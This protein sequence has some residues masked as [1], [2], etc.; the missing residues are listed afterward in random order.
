MK[1]ILSLVFVIIV[2]VT[3]FASC[4]SDDHEHSYSNGKCSCG[5]VDPNYHKHSF[6]NGKCS[7]GAIDPNHR[8]SFVEG[9]CACGEEDPNYIPP[10]K[11]T[12]VDGKCKDCAITDPDVKPDYGEATVFYPGDDLQIVYN[13]DYSVNRG[14]SDTLCTKLQGILGKDSKIDVVNMYAWNTEREIVVGLLDD[15]RPATVVAHKL[16]EKLERE[17]YFTP[18]YVIY[19]DS[20]TIAIAYDYVLS[21]PIQPIE[22]IMDEFIRNFVDGKDYLAFGKGI[23]S[24]GS[25]D[26]IPLQEECDINTIN[27]QWK[28]FEAVAGKE[29]A[30]AMRLLYSLYS[31]D[32]VDWFANLYDPGV[33]AFYAASS[34]RN[35]KDFGPDIEN[36]V[37]IFSFIEN[38][39]MLD[40]VLDGSRADWSV[41]LPPEMVAEMIYFAKSLQDKNGYFYHPQWERSSIDSNIIRRSRDLGRS[42]NILTTLGSAPTYNAPNGTRGDGITADEFWDMYGIGEKPYTYDKSPLDGVP[43][44]TTDLGVSAAEMVSSIILAADDSSNTSYLKSHTAFIDYVLDKVIPGVKSNPYSGGSEIGESQSQVN[45]ADKELGPYV[46]QESDGERYAE[47]DGMTLR[48]IL[49]HEMNKIINPETGF[50]GDVLAGD[51]GIEFRYT[52]G[53]MKSMAMY[54]GLSMP[55][56]EEY[57]AIAA[58]NLMKGLLS[59]EPSENNICEVYN[60]WVSITRLNDNLKFIDNLEVRE[61][62]KRIVSEALDENA[63]AAI[64]NSYNKIKGYKKYDGGFSHYYTRGTASHSGL[65]V[66]TGENQ[67]DV[68]ATCI[69]VTGLVSQIRI[70]LGY[71]SIMPDL[72]TASDWMR[73]YQTL[74]EL[75]PVIKY[76]A[77][78][79]NAKPPVYTFE[80]DETS[81][82]TVSGTSSIV[83]EN[84]DSKLCIT[85][86]STAS[87][88]S[89]K[90]D[91]NVTNPLANVTVFEADV[92]YA[93]IT[94]LSET[95]ITLAAKNL[96]ALQYSPILILLTF[97]GKEDGSKILY[98]DYKNG[99]GNGQKIDTGAVI[100]EWFNI[101]VEYY[102]DG[103]DVAFH[104]KTYI[105]DKLIYV[106]DYIYGTS[107]VSG[108]KPLP[109]ANNVVRATYAM[110]MRFLGE[111]Y[112]DN[113][114]L[115]Q[116][117]DE[118]AKND[119]D[120]SGKPVA[121]GGPAG[122]SIDV[123]LPP[124][125]E[126]GPLMEFDGMPASDRITTSST[127]TQNAHTIISADSGNKVLHLSKPGSPSDYSSSYNFTV[128]TTAKEENANVAVFTADILL[129]NL[130]SISDIQITA[131]TTESAGSNASPFI[132]F[133]TPKGKD[134]GTA[135]K[136]NEFGPAGANNAVNKDLDA[137]VGKWFRVRIEY[138]VTASNT[139]G[140]PTAI[141]YK[142]YINDVLAYTSSS[143]YGK[144]L[145]IN[146]GKIP[147]PTVDSMY[148]ITLSFNSKL[149]G[150]IYIDNV[151]FIKCAGN[152]VMPEA[153]TEVGTNSSLE[154]E[155]GGETPD[156]PGEGGDTHEHKFVEGKCDCGAIDPS[157]TPVDPN[158]DTPE[159]PETP[160]SIL[161]FDKMPAIMSV[162]TSYAENTYSIETL[163]SGNK[164]LVVNKNCDGSYGCSFNMTVA[165]TDKKEDGKLAVFV[166]DVCLE[167]LSGIAEIQLTG[168]YSGG[169]AAADSPFFVLLRPASTAAGAAINYT[170]SEGG[171]AA[172]GAV[173]G[174][175]F[176]I[177]VEYS[178]SD[179][180]DEGVPASVEVKVYVNDTLLET[181]NKAYGANLAVNG[182]TKV[183]PE[184][185]ALT[186]VT[187]SFNSKL[188]GKCYV[189]NLGFFIC[190][191]FVMPEVESEYAPHTHEFIEGKC[192]CGAIDPDYAP[193]H[194]HK[195]VDGVC[196]C[197]ATDPDYAPFDGVIDFDEDYSSYITF[198]TA[199][200]HKE[201]NTVQV[202]EIEGNKVL[203]V[204]K[205]GKDST[206][207]G[208]ATLKFNTTYSEASATVMVFE[209]DLRLE[210]ITGYDTQILLY[211]KGGEAAKKSPF[212][213]P[214]PKIENSWARVTIT[215]KVTETDASGAP[216]AIEYSVYVNGEHQ[217]TKT[218]IYGSDITSG[219]VAI[220][221]ISDIKCIALGLN[222]SFL[223]DA[224]FD[225]VSLKLLESFEVEVPEVESKITFD[226]M[227]AASALSISSPGITADGIVGTNTWEIVTVE[228]EKVLYISKGA[229]GHNAEG[230][231]L[232]FNC[233]VALSATPIV[234]SNEANVMVFEADVMYI[235]VGAT[236][237]LQFTVNSVNSSPFVGLIRP[238]GKEAGS[239]IRISNTGATTTETSA[240]VGEW[241]HIRLEYWI[242]ARDEAGAPTAYEV[243][244]FIN[245][246]A[247]VVSQET[248]SGK[249]IF[250]LDELGTVSMSFNRSNLG[251]YYVDNIDCR[252]DYI[253]P[254]VH[255]YAAAV[256]EKEIP[257]T[258]TSGGSY[259]SV[260]YCSECRAELS[261]VAMTE[262]QLDHTYTD[263]KCECGEADPDY[264]ASG[265]DS[266]ADPSCE[267]NF[268]DGVCDKCGEL[269]PEHNAP[270]AGVENTDPT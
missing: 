42:T 167:E 214:L 133:L 36:G 162:S 123:N 202:V 212:L 100:G 136:Y 237:D 38:S 130:T 66:A 137:K 243:K 191:E 4:V 78:A 70:A 92:K 112:F 234:A 192:D 5:A 219:A 11:H 165:P 13:D 253:E 269:S 194:E 6:A 257:A 241:F 178:I 111:F 190:D 18:R 125:T 61:E 99:N 80:D 184:A 270:S 85:K 231:L 168:K 35:G 138:R 15:T 40:E 76:D 52:N 159:V 236:D 118:N 255:T 74:V 45:V 87:G 148:G 180:D 94:G 154:P 261:R 228:E 117:Y 29:I 157:Y 3:C 127:N 113:V 53:F 173:V 122:P 203:F 84:G 44:T 250:D 134:N 193:P 217:S 31:D 230:T 60:V 79:Q 186:G 196:D 68:D 174:E 64:I 83:K 171:T 90:L 260:V 150:D 2:C 43:K 58:T 181:S 75:T 182:G 163:E 98:S 160:E 239:A 47:Y 95:Q 206:Y 135:L 93:N 10:H 126:F 33:G 39:G 179:Y 264:N 97:S 63:A 222:N 141:E 1:K 20:N 169:T 88:N 188:V 24:T 265:D 26:L 153:Q 69:G 256:K 139:A 232:N 218:D 54:N 268:V 86:T 114:S 106:S 67:S 19:S 164:V 57:A 109:T 108:A 183:L 143:I 104:Y 65:P 103:A 267:H 244:Y 245:D 41:L 200:A 195:F 259:D 9:K 49:V 32:I 124:E 215:Y 56:P 128:K 238:L 155:E 59:D 204:D 120:Y 17:S 132:I 201:T 197:G 176:R 246:D 144:D 50:W 72:Y 107:I 142:T 101:R 161:T 235:S 249:K 156:N 220:P 240:T 140:E 254:H 205:A 105:N 229:T 73:F 224:Y 158:P 121:P 251:E 177:R 213:I 170:K 166:A 23:I 207:S 22:W 152:F 25:I 211:H 221:K 216:T 225:N 71:S 247:P 175:W 34:G 223:G 209:F 62:V 102:N 185:D 77:N 131:K 210:N 7:C 199:D 28:S 96:D 89:I 116:K 91:A 266:G 110:N 226:E 129:K 119:P 242:T 81:S 263:G 48:Q 82:L 189:D 21:S 149:C 30:D 252:L 147:L 8:H 258:C 187:L 208:G 198:T 227:P 151:G 55:Y 233:G 248:R 262:P 46:Y 51:E 37:Q 172:S 145:S 27:E 14:A 12:F 115:T 16:L 146:G